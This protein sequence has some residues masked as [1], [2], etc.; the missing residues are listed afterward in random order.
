LLVDYSKALMLG[1]RAK[2]WPNSVCWLTQ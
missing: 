2:L 1:L